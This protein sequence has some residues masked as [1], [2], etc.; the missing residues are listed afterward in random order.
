MQKR[1]IVKRENKDHR[2]LRKISKMPYLHM[3]ISC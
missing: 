3:H 2:I 1:I